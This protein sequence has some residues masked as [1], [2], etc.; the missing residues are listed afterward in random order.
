MSDLELDLDSI[1]EETYPGI[2]REI[3]NIN[4]L[5][6]DEELERQAS[7]YSWYHGL[8]SICKKKVREISTEFEIFESSIRSE[9]YKRRMEAGEKATEKMMESF[10]K[11]H[12]GFFAL[13]RKQIDMETKYNLLKG[14]VTSLSHKK[15]TL[16]QI[17]S[18]AR[19]EKNIYN[20]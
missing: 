13:A 19:A 16:I 14:I 12:P 20:S 2:A 15:D 8:L 11:C 7:L 4:N 18:N 3:T 17:S 10:V 9:E 6:I 1:T 5:N